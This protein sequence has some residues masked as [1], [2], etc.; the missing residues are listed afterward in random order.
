MAEAVSY[1]T[2]LRKQ[3]IKLAKMFCVEGKGT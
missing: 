2:K 1:R 3:E